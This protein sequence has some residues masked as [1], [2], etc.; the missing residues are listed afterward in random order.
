M[1]SSISVPVYVPTDPAAREA[2]SQYLESGENLLWAG[3]IN[4]LGMSIYA[5]LLGFCLGLAFLIGT[6]KQV[7]LCWVV[8][9]P[10]GA[11]ATFVQSGAVYGVTDRRVFWLCTRFHYRKGPPALPLCDALGHPLRIGRRLPFG[12]LAFGG[13]S[14]DEVL[15]RRDGFL[16]FLGSRAPYVCQ[17]AIAARDKLVGE[18]EESLL[19]GFGAP[20]SRTKT[21]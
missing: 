8:M 5:L 3:R 15:G 14:A 11:L 10:L 6:H 7:L 1:S 17:I 12:I 4:L 21:P 9:P 16:F 18:A 20:P 2:I 19:A 13:N